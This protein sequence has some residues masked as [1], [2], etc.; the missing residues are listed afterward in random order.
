MMIFLALPEETIAISAQTS[1]RCSHSDIW[2]L[3]LDLVWSLGLTTFVSLLG[4]VRA[5]DQAK[6]L[7]NQA[8]ERLDFFGEKA[9]P[10]KRMAQFVI[11]RSA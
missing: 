4:V 5:R 7:V 9:D 8:C 2:I 6:V 11:T 3:D 10:L 1:T